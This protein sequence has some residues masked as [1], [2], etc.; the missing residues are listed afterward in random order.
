M[1]GEAGFTADASEAFEGVDRTLLAITLA[2]VLV[3]LLATYRSPVIALVPLVA[4]GV[5]Y[6]IAAGV[7]FGLSEAGAFRV[8]GQATAI[9]IVLMF[10]AGT[11]YCLLLVSRYREE[12]AVGG[13]AAR[14]I[15]ARPRAAGARS[16]RRARRSW[17]RCSSS[18]SPTSARRRAWARCSRSVSR[19]WS[20]PG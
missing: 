13:D 1:T 7:A 12:V 3:L 11:D 14:A 5:A 8:T 17:P 2:L 18:A 9:L 6:V 16:S 15:S 20:S 10:G 19:S 4:V